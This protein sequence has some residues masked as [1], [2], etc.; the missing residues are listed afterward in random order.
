[1]KCVPVPLCCF[2]EMVQPALTFGISG[3]RLSRVLTGVV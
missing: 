2:V 1:V 3:F